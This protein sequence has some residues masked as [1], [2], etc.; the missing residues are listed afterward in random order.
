[1][2]PTVAQTALVFAGVLAS[3]LIVAGLLL[4]E[5]QTRAPRREP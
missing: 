4:R 2:T 3:A 1:M 5:M